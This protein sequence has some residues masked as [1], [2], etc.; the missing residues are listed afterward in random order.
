MSNREQLLKLLSTEKH[1]LLQR[2]EESQKLNAQVIIQLKISQCP[3][4]AGVPLMVLMTSFQP[5]HIA[6]SET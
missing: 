4:S 6:T 5:K 1:N 2:L 3:P